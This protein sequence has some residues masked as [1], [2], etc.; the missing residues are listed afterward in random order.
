MGVK[1]KIE[2]AEKNKSLIVFFAITDSTTQISSNS[3]IKSLG[4]KITGI[5]YISVSNIGI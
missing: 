3:G 5:A 1:T 4:M 2:I